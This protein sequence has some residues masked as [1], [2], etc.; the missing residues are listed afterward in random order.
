MTLNKAKSLNKI[1]A[2]IKDELTLMHCNRINRQKATTDRNTS[3]VKA[4][5]VIKG[6]RCISRSGQRTVIQL[7]NER[8]R[9]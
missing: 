4:V 6:K 8:Q 5:C 3:K 9:E 2:P 1:N 7:M